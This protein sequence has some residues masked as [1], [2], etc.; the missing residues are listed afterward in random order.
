MATLTYLLAISPVLNGFGMFLK[1]LG[2]LGITVLSLFVL[3]YILRFVFRRLTTDLPLVALGVSQTPLILITTLIGLKLSLQTVPPWAASG[4]M[5]WI[6]RGLTALIFIT[7]TYLIAQLITEVIGYALKQYAQRSEAMW[8]D[9]VVPLLETTLPPIVYIAGVLL[10]IQ[11]LGVDM[12]GL[13]VALGGAAF[14][15]G[16][17]L[18]DILSN[19]FSGL[20]LL[21]D[22]PFR[23]GDIIGFP[24]GSRAIIKSIGVRVTKVY[25]IDS[26]SELYIPNGTLQSDNILNLSRP[27]NHYYY[28]ISIPIKADVDPARAIGVME[29]VIL[30]HPDTMGEIERKLEAIDNYYGY[31]I[32]SHREQQKREAGRLRLL[33][34]QEVSLKL[35]KIENLLTLLA[36]KIGRMEQGG[37]DID[38]VRA[39]QGDYLEIC[40]QIG[41]EMTAYR[42]D[43][44]KRTRLVEITGT[45]AEDTLIRL[46]R[47]W[48]QYWLKDPDLFKE[49]QIALPREWEQRIGLLKAKVNRVFQRVSYP[50]GQE[51]RL[52]NMIESLR[53]WMQESFKY[54][55]N[56]WQDP[57]I[58]V[59]EV[60]QDYSRDTTVRFYVD[61]IKLE[62]CERGERVKSEVR[63]EIIWHLRQ[64]YLSN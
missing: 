33:A 13:L 6:Q 3:F 29:K 25:L 46:I 12:A 7:A 35:S 20:V 63:R 40:E 22:T 37:L 16:F 60:M 19:F 43:R 32:S 23:F 42:Q 17:A 4:V 48:Y 5:P 64:A 53:V 11:S 57:K 49:D 59:N 50:S 8:D 2:V 51:T 21:I 36:E 62:H 39:L 10:T 31:S 55:R 38:E 27:T 1:N 24:D 52:D 26:H 45:V 28:T 56:Q 47:T 18:Q 41:L 44:R 14:I 61:D 9:V 58:W 34:E 15:L 54:S 30:A